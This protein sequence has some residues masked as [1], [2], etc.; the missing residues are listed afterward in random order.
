MGNTVLSGRV[1]WSNLRV[2]Y[3]KLDTALAFNQYIKMFAILSRF[4]HIKMVFPTAVLSEIR[5]MFWRCIPVK[6]PVNK[7]RFEAAKTLALSMQI[8]EFTRGSCQNR[9]YPSMHNI[10]KHNSPKYGD[11]KRRTLRDIRPFLTSNSSLQTGIQYGARRSKTKSR[12]L[13]EL[14]DCPACSNFRFQCLEQWA[15]IGQLVPILCQ[16]LFQCCSNVFQFTEK[17]SGPPAQGI[18]ANLLCSPCS[19]VWFV[20]LYGMVLVVC[21]YGLLSALCKTPQGP[22]CDGLQ[23]SKWQ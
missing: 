15:V 21:M 3:L 5:P 19:N 4:I 9:L 8:A 2:K 1:N 18:P 7:R 13:R 23:G 6:T 10:L 16:C 20:A 22:K 17:I 12:D 11:L 14:C